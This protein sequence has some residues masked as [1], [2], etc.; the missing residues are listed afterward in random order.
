MNIF[1]AL[2][3]DHEVQR[4]LMSLLEET[5][6]DSAARQRNFAELV[7][8]LAA[9]AAA[10]ERCLYVPM[11][12]ADLTQEKARHS[13]A[14]HHELDE[15]VEELQGIGMDSSAWLTKARHLFERVEHHLREEE[16]E[17]FQLAGKVLSEREK[18]SRA[19]DYQREMKEQRE[20]RLAA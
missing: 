20:T 12:N 13:V 17:V 1:E 19:A 10:E 18:T 2:R 16:R 6:G 15:L 7:R 8:E 3:E 4:E 14:E 11:I 9:H 5:S